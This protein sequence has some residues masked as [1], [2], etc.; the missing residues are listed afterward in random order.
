MWILHVVPWLTV[1]DKNS[2]FI[3]M[4]DILKIGFHDT[5]K[6]NIAKIKRQCPILHIIL[7]NVYSYRLLTFIH[8]FV[9]KNTAKSCICV[10]L[11]SVRSECSQVGN[12]PGCFVIVRY[13]IEFIAILHS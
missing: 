1:V 2:K 3:K 11:Q 12:E 4:H 6:R 8:I 10:R 5:H 9:D 7:D 13:C